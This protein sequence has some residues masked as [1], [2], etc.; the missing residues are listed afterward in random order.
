MVGIRIFA[1]IAFFGSTM[2]HFGPR[3]PVRNPGCG[4]VDVFFTGL[5]PFHPLVIEQGFDPNMVNNALRRDAAEIVEAGYNLR[6]ES[7]KRG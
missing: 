6:G 4:D 1:T 7:R 3:P 2:A 5:P